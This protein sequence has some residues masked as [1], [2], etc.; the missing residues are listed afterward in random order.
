ML[1]ELLRRGVPVDIVTDQTSAHDPLSYLPEDVSLDDWHDYADKKPAEFTDRARQS[2]ARHV[3][4]MVGFM[5]AGAEVFDYGNSIRDE[6]RLGGFGRA[7]AFPGFVP[8]YIRPLFAEGKG[9]FRWAA[10]SGDPADIRATDE[11]VLS[12]F[13]ANDHLRKWI[14]AAQ[15]RVAFQ[16]LPARICWLGY[17]ER[18]KAGACVQR[19]RRVGG[20]CPR[21]DRDR[22]R[23]PGRRA[24]SPPP[25]GRPS[26]WPTAPTR[27]P[28]GRC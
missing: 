5:D 3:E 7:F 9:P 26:R 23:P 24:R 25:T 14:R 12:L 16:G 11:A 13:P 15:E 17:G 8:A 18:D 27:S 22:P 6:A 21:A 10:L 20:E 4:A 1:P 19:P 2:M 28:T